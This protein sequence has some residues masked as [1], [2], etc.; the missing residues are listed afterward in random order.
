MTAPRIPLPRYTCHKVVEAAVITKVEFDEEIPSY[1]IHLNVQAPKGW[2]SVF[3]RKPN[4]WVKK[5]EPKVGMVF[6]R[7]EDGYES[8]SPK[9]AFDNGYSPS[10]QLIDTSKGD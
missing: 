3:V 6:V 8:V 5:H 4:D 9:A 2:K 7:Y 1:L 10:P